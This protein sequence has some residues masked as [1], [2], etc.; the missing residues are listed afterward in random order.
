MKKSFGKWRIPGAAV[1][2]LAGCLGNAAFGAAMPSEETLKT[3]ACQVV[4][5]MLEGNFEAVTEKFDAVMTESLTAKQ[6]EEGFVAAV[7]ALGEHIGT[8]S[9]EGVSQDVYYVVSV[10]EEFEKNG[11]QV[12]VVY[13]SE[14]LIAGMRTT[15]APLPPKQE[16]TEESEGA[17]DEA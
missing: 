3:D 7:S 5:D 9:V 16:E 10:L 12:N 11:L 14:G 2:L 1:F 13:D 17:E 15:Y 8:V 4:A 6:L